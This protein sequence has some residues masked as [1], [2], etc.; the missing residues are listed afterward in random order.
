VR[1][2]EADTDSPK[3]E[4][5]GGESHHGY[6]KDNDDRR[7]FALDGRRFYTDLRIIRS[8][9]ANPSVERSRTYGVRQNV[10]GDCVQSGM[11]RFADRSWK[12]HGV[13][14]T[15]CH[16]SIC[17]GGEIGRRARLR[18]WWRNP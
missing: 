7:L 13:A 8:R 2:R 17:Q 4:W 3:R 6:D 9:H 18:I 1:V 10:K 11:R 5:S 14:L 15:N 16:P 12:L